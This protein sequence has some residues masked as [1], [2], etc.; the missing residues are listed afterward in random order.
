MMELKDININPNY[1]ITAYFDGSCRQA[2]GRCL[3]SWAYKYDVRR[4]NKYCKTVM[5]MGVVDNIGVLSANRIEL[6]AC[7]NFLK[8]IKD[9]S[10]P[11][12]IKTDS[13]YVIKGTTLCES[14]EKNGWR[15]KRNDPIAYADLWMQYHDLIKKFSCVK[16]IKC[17]SK[18]GSKGNDLVDSLCRTTINNFLEGK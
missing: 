10:I 17:K 15:S 5:D 13:E 18:S 8:S 11:M 14:W 1:K 12:H 3:H 2:K 7:I 9:R 6:I 4:G 16:F